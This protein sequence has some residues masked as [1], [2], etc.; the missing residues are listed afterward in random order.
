MPFSRNIVYL[1]LLVE[2]IL[3]SSC[4]KESPKINYGHDLCSECSMQ[5]MDTKYGAV[6]ITKKGKA[7]KFDSIECLVDFYLKNV[8]PRDEDESM[9]VIDF[10]KPKTLIKAESAIYIRNDH[11][12]SP[13]GINVA[14]FITEDAAE[15]IMNRYG[16][17]K[18][19][20]TDLLKVLKIKR[21]M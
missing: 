3:L 19:S 16:G 4:S 6:L 15:K 13:M 12:H 11:F 9:W 18:L 7:Y 8:I 2:V 10:T 20:W 21:L 14:A 5:I 17:D 1:L